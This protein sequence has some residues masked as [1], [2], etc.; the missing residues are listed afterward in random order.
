[1]FFTHLLH[2]GLP[3]LQVPQHPKQVQLSRQHH[4]SLFVNLLVRGPVCNDALQIGFLV[5]VLLGRGFRLKLE[6][7]G[8]LGLGLLG[9]SLGLVL[10]L[11]D[12]RR[13]D[14]VKGVVAVQPEE[15]LRELDLQA[16]GEGRQ[17]LRRA[18]KVR[19]R[20]EWS[21]V[22]SVVDVAIMSVAILRDSSRHREYSRLPK[23]RS[24]R[25]LTSSDS[26]G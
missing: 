22:S 5:V 11:E 4:L 23:A 3:H 13:V 16:E 24:L 25:S 2:L 17:E 8:G 21:N 20:I 12:G 19:I 7:R 9:L 1:M 14:D 26:D 6:E 15:L 10:T 18:K